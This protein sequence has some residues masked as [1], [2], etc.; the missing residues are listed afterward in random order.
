MPVNPVPGDGEF[1]LYPNIP[2]AL[3]AGS[4]RLRAEQA[5]GSDD[6]SAASALPVDRLDVHLDVR[7]PRLVLPPD[8]VLSTFPPAESEG[9]YGSRLP[10]VVIKRR[11][12]PWERL[13][14]PS[15]PTTTP[16]LALVVVAEGEATLVPNVPADD[17]VTPGVVLP[18]AIDADVGNCLEIRQSVVHSIFPTKKDVP[19]LAHARH[20]DINDTEL[21]LGDDDGFL[22]VVVANRLPLSGRDASGNEIPVKYT[23]CLVNLEQQW[24]RLL[25][26]A[27]TP[28]MNTTLFGIDQLLTLSTAAMDKHVM[29]GETRL[30]TTDLTRKQ[31][32]ATEVRYIADVQYDV[33]DAGQQRSGVGFS[34]PVQKKTTKRGEVS[35]VLAT[36]FVNL[37][38]Q[39]TLFDPLLR[40]P[41]LLHWRFS[42]T[43]NVTFEALMKGLDSGL[44]GTTAKTPPPSDAGRLP[45]ELVDTGHVGLTQRTRRGD[46]VRAWYRGPF[47]PHPADD[48]ASARLP[49]AH[50]ADQLRIVI[51]DGREDLSLASAFEIGRL[52][53]LANPNMVAALLRWRQ[54]HYA[55]VRRTAI[56]QANAVFLG[57]L[58]GFA[59]TERVSADKVGELSRA[60]TRA[61]S[62]RPADLLGDPRA[63]VD[64]GRTLPFEGDPNTMMA[65]AFGLPTFRGAPDTILAT[66]QQEPVRV[67]PVT[68]KI[69]RVPGAAFEE[70]DRAV[71]E[72]SLDLRVDRIATD[73]L[74]RLGA[75]APKG[76]AK[77]TASRGRAKAAAPRDALDEVIERLSRTSRKEPKA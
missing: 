64:P 46:T 17:T 35:G 40:F 6:H 74:V 49:L 70:L 12:L 21:M 62:K 54:L 52:L 61:V 26:T 15:T 13:V 4:Y 5:L 72:R 41:V 43:G 76:T 55:T 59:M 51:P 34:K 36:E 69:T 1:V 16:W 47:V 23:A 25:P 27:P 63:L 20:V 31:A 37:G 68:E 33:G 71:L 73:A 28:K 24:D 32:G 3:L 44:L 7:S 39:A 65:N 11:T 50:A 19:L 29:G 18:G 48:R 2:P 38:L 66:L 9:A 58:D 75:A 60:M 53:A 42:S 22:A 10:Q 8:Q 30:T 67:V 45:L 77:K 14:A 57:A 56:W